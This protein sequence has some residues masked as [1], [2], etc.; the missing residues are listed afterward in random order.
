MRR[1][2]QESRRGFTLV[3]LLVVLG[4]VALLTA[5]AIPGLARLGAFSRDEFR[6]SVQDVSSLLR[7]AQIYASTYN[8]NTAVVYNLD[9]WSDVEATLPDTEPVSDPLQEDGTDP[10]VAVASPIIDS[11]TGNPIRHLE[12]AAI[13]YQLPDSLGQLGGRFV[14]VPGD[15]GEF[16]PLPEGMS[17]L[18]MNPELP[19]VPNSGIP[20]PFYFENVRSNFRSDATVNAAWAMGLLKI[21]VA[22]GVPVGEDPNGFYDNFTG[23]TGETFG[24]HVFKPDGR[25]IVNS[26]RERYTLYI[27]PTADRVA[28]ERLIDPELPELIATADNQTNML[29]RK[30]H[31]FKSTGRIETPKNF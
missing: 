18:L 12:A 11:I 2:H 22:L 5:I 1:T 15:L 14:P 9:N 26:D 6:R 7:S 16:H 21:N 19:D 29:Y 24:A 8:V 13:M 30:I 31:L 4:I 27:A 28:E 10:A 3:E 23:F 17:I 25:L 20:D